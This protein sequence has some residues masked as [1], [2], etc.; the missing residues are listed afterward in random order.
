MM[1]DLSFVF[2][3]SHAERN[4]LEQSRGEIC[5]RRDGLARPNPESARDADDEYHGVLEHE[6][7]EDK[8]WRERGQI[9]HGRGGQRRRSGHVNKRLGDVVGRQVELEK[10]RLEP[11]FDPARV[12]GLFVEEAANDNDR[13]DHV[14]N[15]EDSDAYHEFL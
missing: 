13:R 12:D 3:V 1:L 9:T 6:Q 14:E 15:G 7:R 5:P 8:R 11:V 10:V 2:R 4:A